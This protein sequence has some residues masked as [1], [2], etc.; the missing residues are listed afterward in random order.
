[1]AIR[2]KVAELWQKVRGHRAKPHCVDFGEV[3]CQE[4]EAIT[5][6]RTK[7]GR[8]ILR[9]PTEQPERENY[10]KVAVF[11]TVGIA[12]SGGGIRSAAFCLGAL[13][14]LELSKMVTRK[15]DYLSSVSG[16]G[17][18]AA[19]LAVQMS[20]GDRAF[21]FARPDPDDYRDSEPLAHIRD[22]SNYLFPKG[23][24][25]L[26][27][28]LAIW[29]RGLFAN[30]L[31]V[32][33]A[34]LIAAALTVFL[35]TWP[36]PALL[37]DGPVKTVISRLLGLLPN[38]YPLS[39]A[40]AALMI[41]A[42]IAWAIVRSFEPAKKVESISTTALAFKRLLYVL[43]VLVAAESQPIIIRKLLNG[44]APEISSLLD[45]TVVV[46]T[47]ISAAVVAGAR[48]IADVLKAVEGTP[49]AMALVKRIS[50]T[51][52]IWLAAAAVPVLLYIAYLALCTWSLANPGKTAGY[53]VASLV[54]IL[55]ALLL[56]PNANSLHRL[57][58]QR[59]AAAFLSSGNND[60]PSQPARLSGLDIAAI[61]YPLINAALNVQGSQ[62]VNRRGRNADFFI[63]SPLFSGSDSTGYVQTS[64][65]EELDGNLTIATAMA[66]SGAAVSSNMGSQ[67]IRPL[68]PTLTLLNIR[69]GYWLRNPRVRRGLSPEQIYVLAEMFSKLDEKHQLVYLTDGGH[70][71]NLGV[72]E[73]LRRR[74]KF[75]IAVDAEADPEIA[76]PSLVK[77]QRYARID[78]GVRI[79]IP[80]QELRRTA[81]EA[82]QD[83]LA[84]AEGMHCAIGTIDYA[85]RGRGLLLYVKS[86]LSGDENDYTRNYAVR[87]PSFPHETTA[88]QLFSEEQFEVYRA[89]GFHAV[90][91]L[92]T[93]REKVQAPGT[94]DTLDQLASGKPD[95]QALFDGLRGLFDSKPAPPGALPVGVRPPRH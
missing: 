34:L 54:M 85:N 88:D 82:R 32:A 42:M 51:L 58:R 50:G 55:L 18:T 4:H 76:C 53:F 39:F 40:I 65:M 2:K 6:R 7:H 84:R 68:A 46:L 78:L 83:P 71:E 61:P 79:D 9:V 72:Y 94:I 86:S 26:G 33:P 69:L 15:T 20:N 80:W 60:R 48:W 28:N 47:A 90:H 66:I 56:S 13:Q 57:Y 14:A 12:L 25:D 27:V 11:E 91:S 35:M 3:L 1:M 59:L 21:P 74:C 37:P 41:L 45:T 87:S 10:G 17:Y 52:A 29:L 5:P 92:A 44:L 70:I 43:V 93:S 63:F 23:W 62:E 77:V 16:G 64:R 30:V 36:T 73:L 31:W 24:S 81:R 49:G 75:I 8:P 89:L 19:A 67:S 22:R 95:V 38:S